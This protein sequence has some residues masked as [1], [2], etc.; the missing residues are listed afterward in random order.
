MT[1]RSEDG[2]QAKVDEI[3]KAAKDD[4]AKG[5]YVTESQMYWFTAVSGSAIGMLA[6]VLGIMAF[7]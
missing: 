3:T 1:P 4:G 6:V 2:I 7:N 5:R